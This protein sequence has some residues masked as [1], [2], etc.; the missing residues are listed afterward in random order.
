M[1]VA[2]PTQ[3]GVCRGWRAL[4]NPGYADIH[5]R[6]IAHCGQPRSRRSATLNPDAGADHSTTKCI[7]TQAT[8]PVHSNCAETPASLGVSGFSK[9]ETMVVHSRVSGELEMLLGK[10]RELKLALADRYERAVASG[11]T[12]TNAGDRRAEGELRQL[13]ARIRFQESEVARMGNPTIGKLG[14]NRALGTAGQLSPLVFDH[15]EMRNLHSKVLRQEPARIEARGDFS[16]GV[17]FMPSQLYPVPT[18]PIHEHR[19]MEYLPGFALDAPSMEY[20]QVNSVTGYAAIVAEG[21]PKPELVMNTTH[22][23]IAAVKISAHVGVSWESVQDYESFTASVQIE[24]VRQ[25]V[26][27]ENLELITGNLGSTPSD[28]TGLLATDGILV[29]HLG[30]DPG[31]T[32][33]LDAFEMSIA[34]LRVG[35]S[36]AEPDLIIISPMT[37]SACRRVKDLQDRYL[38]NPDPS[39]DEPETIWGITV[40]TTTACPPGIAILVDRGKFGRCVVREP[41]AVRVGFSGSDFTDNIVRYVG[42]ERLNLA[43]ERPSAILALSGLP[44]G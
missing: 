40:M 37:W 42:E 18:F 17:D 7:F 10:R 39:A 25:V 14:R 20:I 41:L 21:Q 28:I 32:T 24:L 36:L 23:I 3:H 6:V 1:I 11:R 44:T 22:K 12:E 4:A 33:P 2:D 29:H 30:D 34:E 38:I 13:D 5:V 8:G 19:L 15:E 31:G 27:T 35:P 26:D 16:S 9:A 43:V